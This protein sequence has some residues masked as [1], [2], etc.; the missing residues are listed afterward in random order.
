[1]PTEAQASADPEISGMA[2][3]AR[4]AYLVVAWLFVAALLAQVYLIGLAFL[5]ARPT[6]EAHVGFGHSLGILLLPMLILTYVAR[7]PRSLKVRTWLLLG[8]Y[9]LQSEVFAVIRGSLPVMAALHP[10]LALA[11]FWLAVTV[12][13]QARAYAHRRVP[14]PAIAARS[15]EPTRG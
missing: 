4:V 13:L 5:A 3:G 2:Y 14:T 11:L 9:I 12:A 15:T 1:M 6:L 8:L 7:H 10:V